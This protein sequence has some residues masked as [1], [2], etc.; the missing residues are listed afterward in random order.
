VELRHVVSAKCREEA[1]PELKRRIA[2]AIAEHD[3]ANRQLPPL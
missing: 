2:E 3:R 1:P